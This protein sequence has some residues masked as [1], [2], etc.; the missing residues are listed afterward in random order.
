MI[1]PLGTMDICN[2]FH[3]NGANG[4]QDISLKTKEVGLEESRGITKVS[5]HI[6]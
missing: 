1:H 6:G 4:S 2:T 3:G 5:K